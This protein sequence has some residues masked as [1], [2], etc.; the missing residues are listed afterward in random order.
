MIDLIQRAAKLLPID[1]IW[2]NPDCGLKT[3]GWP[4]TR[5]ALVNMVAAAKKLRTQF[6]LPQGKAILKMVKSA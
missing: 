4:E 5:A 2:V 1:L 3:R 6:N